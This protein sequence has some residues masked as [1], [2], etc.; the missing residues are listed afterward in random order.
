MNSYFNSM[1]ILAKH[2]FPH[3]ITFSAICIL[4]MRGSP[5]CSP[6]HCQLV[7]YPDSKTNLVFEWEV[8]V[9]E[10]FF[11]K[12]FL[13]ICL[14]Y[15]PSVSSTCLLKRSKFSSNSYQCLCQ[16]VL[17][18]GKPFLLLGLSVSLS[19][20]S[21]RLTRSIRIYSVCSCWVFILFHCYIHF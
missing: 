3:S 10:V 17:L 11:K 18:C 14:L 13:I 2:K 4:S 16:G 5:Y 12:H 7:L 8:E 15:H 9:F 20:S 19:A 1:F 21:Q 6:R